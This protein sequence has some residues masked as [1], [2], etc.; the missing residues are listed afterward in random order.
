M[1]WSKHAID[2]GHYLSRCILDGPFITAQYPA[3]FRNRTLE[4]F[5]T[6][7]LLD[8]AM[9]HRTAQPARPCRGSCP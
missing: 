6:G 1:A 2:L 7:N 8:Q 3:V 4:R 9:D 5:G